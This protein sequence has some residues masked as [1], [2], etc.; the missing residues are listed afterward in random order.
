MGEKKVYLMI[1]V[2]VPFDKVSEFNE[3]WGRESLP[4]WIKLGAKHIGSF[5]NFVGGPINEIIRLFEF[6]DIEHW[7]KWERFLS[8]TNEGKDILK[9][10]SKYILTLERRLLLPIY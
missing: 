8:D 6:E 5:E 1:R 3:F 10:L 4:N 2:Q 7:Q 9:R